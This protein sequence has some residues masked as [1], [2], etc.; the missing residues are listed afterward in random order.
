LYLWDSVLAT[1]KKAPVVFGGREG[2]AIA[3]K[4]LGVTGT[5]VRE[6]DL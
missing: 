6:E 5:S 2:M 1:G 4:A 3:F